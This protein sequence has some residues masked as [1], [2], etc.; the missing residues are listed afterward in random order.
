MNEILIKEKSVKE[1][2]VVINNM[3]RSKIYTRTGDKGHSSLFSGERRPKDDRTFEALGTVDELNSSI[4]I[5]LCYT[6]NKNLIQKLENVQSTLFEIGSLIAK[7]S[8][9]HVFES[10]R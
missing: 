7:P 9:D 6:V 10:S 3:K 4:G 8:D 5:A 2:H 1:I